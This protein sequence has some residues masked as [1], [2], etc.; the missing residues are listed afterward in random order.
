M[1][2]R[3]PTVSTWQ[4]TDPVDLNDIALFVRVVEAGGFSAAA[5]HLR[6]PKS[7]VSRG[8][9]RLE[10]SL[11]A[12]LLHRSTRAV[13]LTDVG[14]A[15]HERVRAALGDLLEASRA[16]AEASPTPRGTLRVAAP[17]DVGAE[18]LPPL[19]AAFVAL[20]PEVRVEVELSTRD[21]D[22]VE[23]GFDVAIRAGAVRDLSVVAR[24]LQ[25]IDFRLYAAPSYLRR[26][27]EPR[28]LEDL[29]TRPCVL[30][31]PAGGACVWRLHD[32]HGEHEVTVRGSAAADDMTFVRRA[33]VAGA[34]VAFLPDLVGRQLV[35]RGELA[36]VLAGYRAAG[37]PLYLILPTSRQLPSNV[38]A[39]CDFLLDA[40][41]QSR[42]PGRSA[43]RR[44]IPVDVPR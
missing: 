6:S 29:A 17:T 22:L 7:S 18:V 10:R 16:V 40:F 20:Y 38:R 4:P 32:D 27:G 9:S 3:P 12:R 15:Y 41:P 26:V 13:T 24:K 1:P 21:V 34:G 8:V 30:Y 11:G 36:P 35:E 42:R 23:G 14:R 37:P 19:V 28:R 33:A 43:K 2:R 44:A 31:R 39:F 25:D 5:R